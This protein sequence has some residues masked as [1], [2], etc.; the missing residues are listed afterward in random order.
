MTA[1]TPALTIDR[2]LC[3]IH[4]RLTVKGWNPLIAMSQPGLNTRW[5][6][7]HQLGIHQV[8]R[9]S[10]ESQPYDPSPLRMLGMVSLEDQYEEEPLADEAA[11]ELR[12][13][14]AVD[15]LSDGLQKSGVVVHC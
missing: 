3:W 12:I 10:E 6:E 8:L 9:L 1:P 15:L 14:Q 13:K 11:E 5:D 7:L 2:P 4:F